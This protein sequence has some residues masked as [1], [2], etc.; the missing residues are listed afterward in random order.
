MP[1]CH[2]YLPMR[3]ACEVFPRI[4]SH[5]AL[6]GKVCLFRWTRTGGE[7]KRRRKVTREITIET[8]ETIALRSLPA[9]LPT[10]CPNCL[11]RTRFLSLESASSL[12]GVEVP[13]L[14]LWVEEGK[15][16]GEIQN[17]GALT[18]CAYSISRFRLHRQGAGD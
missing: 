15:L 18:I 7:L 9:N 14:R 17:M 3:G 16:H 8:T 11:R 4:L 12:L 2:A 1:F 5:P 10:W 13:E 6:R